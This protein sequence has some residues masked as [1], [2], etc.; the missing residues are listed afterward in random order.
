MWTEINQRVNNPIKA[1]LVELVD[2]EQV[3]IEDEV[4]KYC[5]SNVTLQLAE[6]GVRRVVNSWNAHHIPGKGIPNQLSLNRATSPVP[7]TQFPCAEETAVMYNNDMPATLTAHPSFGK[8]PFTCEQDRL[9]CT[10]KV[11]VVCPDMNP[12]FN[13]LRCPDPDRSAKRN[14][15]AGNIAELIEEMFLKPEKPTVRDGE[16]ITVSSAVTK[17]QSAQVVLRAMYDNK[18]ENLTRFENEL[19][20]IITS[21]QFSLS[22]SGRGLVKKTLGGMITPTS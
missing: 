11:E 22:P 2:S 20:E 1:A 18:G 10:T 6:I 12:L 21:G 5:T 8:D 19:Q 16:D 13:S 4:V 9:E 15:E 17:V 7:A 3:D 14:K